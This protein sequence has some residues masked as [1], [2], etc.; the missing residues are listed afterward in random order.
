MNFRLE[1]L[2][3]SKDKWMLC[4]RIVCPALLLA[5]HVDHSAACA[6]T[7]VHM[8]TIC[9]VGEYIWIGDSE[10]K[11]TAFQ[12]GLKKKKNCF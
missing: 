11:I 5:Q 10:S 12:Y 4:Q 2:T 8:T 6:A 1:L 7:N 9:S 3:G